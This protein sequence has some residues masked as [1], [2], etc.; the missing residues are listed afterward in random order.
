MIG[1]QDILPIRIKAG[2]LDEN[3]PRRDLSV[4]PHHAMYFD[5]VLIEARDLVND[6]SI[7]Q[8]VRIDEVEYFHIELDT[9][10]IIVAEGALSET[11]VDDHSR[12][13]FHNVHEYRALYPAAAP[14][15]RATYYAPRLQR[16]L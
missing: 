12:G 3:I 14:P 10:D 6:V 5:G 8:A 13:M 11:F 1:R 9:H 15:V 16:G 7:V 2:A 4:S